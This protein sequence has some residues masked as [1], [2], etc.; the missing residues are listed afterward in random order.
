MA[1]RTLTIDSAAELHVRSGQLTVQRETDSKPLQ[2]DLDDLTCIVL[3][4]LD[5][6]LS[7]GALN[8]ISEHGITILGC[9]RNF[10]PTN[11]M[12]PFARNS[13]Y[14]EVVDAQLSMTLPFQK[15][16]WK[17]LVQQKITNQSELL[18]LNGHSAYIELVEIAQAVR[19]GDPDNREAVAAKRYFPLLK[20]GYM[21]AEVSPTSSILNYGYAVVRSSIARSIV[22]HGFISSVGLHH[23]NVRNEF[24]L[25]DDLIEPFRPMVDLQMLAI[26][27]DDED[28]EHLSRRAR[29]EMTTV[30]R[31][32]CIVDGHKTSCLLAIEQVVRSL[33]R[34][35]EKRDAHALVLPSLI[36]IEKVEQ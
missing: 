5:I 18:R 20:P 33:K 12:L 27:L 8:I 31:N 36:P 7:T 29:Q 32:A 21:R 13:R 19:S 35:V 25:V 28:A 4:N 1:F 23:D 34:A 30:L 9:G 24:N 26:N 17:K 15:R 22:A 10:M 16:L 11:I 3:A 6:T 14:S 2:I